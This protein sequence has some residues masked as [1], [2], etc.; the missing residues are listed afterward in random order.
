MSYHRAAAFVA[1]VLGSVVVGCRGKT[2]VPETPPP[3]VIVTR[4][5]S[6]P[7]RNYFEY[8]GYLDTTETVEVRAR[9]KGLL[10]GIHYTEGTEVAKGDPLYDIDQR[11]YITAEKKAM[12]ELGKAKADVL[13]W[14]AQIKLAEAELERARTASKSGVGAKTDL[15]KATAQLDVNKAEKQAA[16]ASTE[17]ADAALHTARI[18]LGYT[19]IFAEIGGQISRTRVT[20]G[21]LVG[22]SDQTLLT[23]IVRMDELYIYFDAPETDLVEYQQSL[24]ATKQPA[25]TSG[26]IEV[27]VRVTGE[28]GYP[29]RGKI[30]FRENRVD[31]ATGTVRIRGRLPNPPSPTGA[32]ALYPGLYAHIRVP[33]GA[34]RPLL[35]IP[36]DCIMTGQEG[37]YV[38]VVNQDNTVENRLVTLGPSVWKAPPPRPDVIVAGWTLVNPKAA[39][40]DG[41]KSPAQARRSVKSMVAITAGLKPGDRVIVEGIQKARPTQP[42]TPEEWNLKAP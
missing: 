31:I 11:E 2:A 4:P 29:H 28:E 39:P 33:A 1:L 19:R 17:A 22:Q 6:A 42:V 34:A 9:V 30:D 12:A 7:V 21:N 35:T 26:N 16:E 36:E 18:Q 41:G 8:N 38:Y 27:E 32:R 25:P 23:T 24:M 3:G 13:N 37:R 14:T 15:D 10:T 20:V 40:A 5:A